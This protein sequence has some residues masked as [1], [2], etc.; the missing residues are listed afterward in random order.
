MAMRAQTELENSY[1]DL[2][3]GAGVVDR[4]RGVIEVS[5]PDAVEFLQGQ[6]TNDVGALSPGHGAYALLLNPKGRILADMTVLALGAERLWV[7][8]DQ[9]DEVFSNLSMYK[10]GR[11]VEVTRRASW[12]AS[13]IGPRAREVLG[14]ELPAREHSFAT[15]DI[16]GAEVL[17]VATDL[18]V[19]LIAEP[20]LAAPVRDH[21]IER[22]AHDSDEEAAEVLRIESGRP[23]YG[24]DMSADNLPGEA[25]LEQ[26]AVSFTKGCYVGQEPVARMHHRGHPNRH[27]RGLRLSQPADP[28]AA[29]VNKGGDSVGHISSSC[30][31]PALGPIALAIVRR[32]VPP[33]ET[34]EV[35]QERST[36][37]VIELP[38]APDA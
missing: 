1:R 29:I 37:T 31:S 4:Q 27:L 17:A 26:R 18:G 28:G 19:D 3:E 21:L 6:V 15:L 30:V 9:D 35:A 7:I 32:E 20:S 10:I 16:D 24:T 22:G 2:R 5:G 34:V 25:G 11:E 12:I 33:G 13:L 23:R 8:T 36:A 38:F 14:V